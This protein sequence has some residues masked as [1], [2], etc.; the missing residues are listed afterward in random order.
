MT[1][2]TAYIELRANGIKKHYIQH[3]DVSTTFPNERYP[4]QP[5]ILRLASVDV[6]GFTYCC[7]SKNEYNLISIP[8]GIFQYRVTTSWKV[9][10][11]KM[12]DNIAPDD[13]DGMTDENRS[14]Y[15]KIMTDYFNMC[16]EK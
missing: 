7:V 15:I 10:N 2:L 4:K 11:L 6:D 3:N 12:L 5:F 9:Y 1:F 16:N 13:V 14:E 8:D